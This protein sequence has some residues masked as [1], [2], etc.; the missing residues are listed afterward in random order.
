LIV[1]SDPV[2]TNPSFRYVLAVHV[3]G[4]APESLLSVSLPPH[5]WALVPELDRPLKRQLTAHLDTAT[6]EQMQAVDTALR[7]VLDLP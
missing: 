3:L 5:G 1:S 7:A 4:E 6:A 2:N